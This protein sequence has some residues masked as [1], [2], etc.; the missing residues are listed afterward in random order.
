[1]SWWLDDALDQ[2]DYRAICDEDGFE[3]LRVR[4]CCGARED[5]ASFAAF[6]EAAPSGLIRVWL[7]TPYTSYDQSWHKK[8]GAP[9]GG[10]AENQRV[11]S[12][13]EAIHEENRQKY[14]MAIVR[15]GQMLLADRYDDRTHFILCR[16]RR[17]RTARARFQT[18]N[19]RAEPAAEAGHRWAVERQ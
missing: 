19:V 10:N 7:T 14:G 9:T 8:P 18:P 16:T 1:L 6:S 4:L 12:D 3:L 5:L 13:Y 17:T 11:A 2:D 15:I